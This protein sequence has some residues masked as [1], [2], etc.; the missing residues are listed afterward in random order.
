MATAVSVSCTI[1]A[2]QHLKFSEC[3]FVLDAEDS[4]PKRNFSCTEKKFFPSQNTHAKSLVYRIYQHSII[5]RY[6]Q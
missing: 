5:P 2:V 6:L 3:M 1:I 4:N